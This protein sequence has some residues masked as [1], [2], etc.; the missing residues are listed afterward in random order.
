MFLPP[1]MIDG[2]LAAHRRVHVRQQRGR[3]LHEIDA[4]LI[5][6]RDKARQIADHPAAQRQH[7]A[8]APEAIGD[9]DV[10][11][12]AGAWPASCAARHRAG[13]PRPAAGLAALCLTRSAYSG[14]TTVLLISSSVAGRK[15]VRPAGPRAQQ[16]GADQDR[17]GALAQADGQGLH[18]RKYS[19]AV[20]GNYLWS[21]R[22]RSAIRARR[23]LPQRHLVLRTMYSAT[24]RTR[25]WSVDTCRSAI[26]R[27]SGSR[28]RISSS[29]RA[30]SAPCSSGRCR[31]RPARSACCATEVSRYTTQPRLARSATVVGSPGPRR[32]RWPA[33][34]AARAVSS[35]MTSRSRRRKPDFALALEDQRDI[36][37]AVRRSI[38]WSLS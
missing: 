17:I 33:R 24:D 37:A 29:S 8:I 35:A 1:G 14:A 22:G 23:R 16:P 26:S 3:H 7:D 2:G 5:A 12:A 10:E 6:G 32:R 15:Y 34:C 13:S 19:A 27:Y 9:H 21:R 18:G 28:T 20:G 25:R 38:S 4:A 30:G 31:V 11:Y 36:G